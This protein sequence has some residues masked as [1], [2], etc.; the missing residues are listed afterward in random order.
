MGRLVLVLLPGPR[1]VPR[2]VLHR[3]RVV[4]LRVLDDAALLLRIVDAAGPGDRRHALDESEEE[5]A[6]MIVFVV[7]EL[8]LRPVPLHQ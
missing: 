1:R 3:G 2:G 8:H 4:A 6:R 5:G 7:H